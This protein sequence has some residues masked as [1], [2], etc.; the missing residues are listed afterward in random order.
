MAPT[1]TCFWLN[2][3]KI[4]CW[5][6]LLFV[7]LGVAV[8]YI[9][10]TQCALKSS[11]LELKIMERGTGEAMATALE[12]VLMSFNLDINNLVGICKLII[13]IFVLWK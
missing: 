7:F 8:R 5:S 4:T 10:T 2:T 1:I 11:F 3:R 12:D 6:N 13:V 9:N